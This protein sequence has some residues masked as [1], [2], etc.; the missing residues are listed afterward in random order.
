MKANTGEHFTFN[1]GYCE[2]VWTAQLADM[3]KAYNKVIY[4]VL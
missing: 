2:T 1:G 3:M 4:R